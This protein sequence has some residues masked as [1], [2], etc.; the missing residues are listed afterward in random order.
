MIGK[1][2]GTIDSIAGNQI[3]I[4]VSGVGYVVACSAHTLR[5]IGTAGDVAS[6]LIETQVRE[7]SI[8]L[9]GFAGAEERDWFRLLTTVQGVGAKVALAILSVLP[10]GRLAQAIAAQDKAALAQAEGV[11]PKLALRIVTELKDKAAHFVIPAA[12]PAGASGRAAA[13]AEGM[14]SDAVSALINLG[15]RRMEAFAAVA[16]AS[17][18]LGAD[19]KIDA[20]IRA[21]LAELSRKENV[22]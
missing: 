6:L 5:Q 19:A 22:A 16:R 11:G 9:F 7:D 1:L 15:Y 18:T 21:S 17:Q 13:A 20:L 4:D 12:L 3:V 10:P 8:S 14:A 2:T